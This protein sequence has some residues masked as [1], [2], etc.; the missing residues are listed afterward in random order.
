MGVVIAGGS[1]FPVEYPNPLFG[2]HAGV[3]RQS[4][5]NLPVGGWLPSQKQTRAEALASFTEGAAYAAHQEKTLGK[6]LPGYW[7][8]F[9]LLQDDYFQQPA[10][11]IWKNEVL[12]TYVAGKRIF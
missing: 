1:D 6:L 10:Q 7:A 5:D 2:L 8:D 3:T 12:A 9:I 4:Q 11:D